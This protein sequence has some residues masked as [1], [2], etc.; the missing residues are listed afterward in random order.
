MAEPESLAEALDWARQRIDPLEARVLLCHVAAISHATL[1]GFGERPLALDA[2][3]R[4]EALVRRRAAGEPVAYLTGAREFY[5]RAFR[6]GNGVLIPRPETE[7]LVGAALDSVR[8]RDG[9][10]V[11]DL[12]TGSGIV[13][14]TLALELG[15]RAASVVAVDRSATALGYASMNAGA[16]GAAV[17][18]RLGDWFAGLDDLSFDLIAANP[19]YVADSDPHLACGDLRFE[20]IQ[21]LAGGDDGLDA[22]RDIVAGA[23]AR[24]SAGASLLI[25]H[26][27]DQASEVRRML[28]AAGFALVRSVRD[29]AGIERVTTGRWCVDGIRRRAVD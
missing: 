19:P 12:G 17:D 16:L 1:R 5:S 4:F 21:A 29:L 23:G 26:G 9:I 15:S 24:L 18:F 22:I 8:G 28:A 27:H 13:A 7:Q 11:L 20:P 6:V 25:E 2:W 3:Q 10:R 14:I